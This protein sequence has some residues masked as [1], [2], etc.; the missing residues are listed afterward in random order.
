MSWFNSELVVSTK[1]HLWWLFRVKFRYDWLR[2]VQVIIRIGIRCR[3]RL[4]V[5][6]MG[7][8]FQFLTSKLQGASFRP[9]E[10]HIFE[11]NDAF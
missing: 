6:L 4:K 2:S 7:P 9:P 11:R 1:A 3:S 8:K 5:L 10:R